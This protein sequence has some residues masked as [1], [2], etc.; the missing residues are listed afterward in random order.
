MQ[1]VIYADTLFL[2][3]FF[4]NTVVLLI[5]D[6]LIAA[7][8]PIWRLFVSAAVGAAYSLLMFFEGF[9]FL[10]GVAL[11]VLILFGIFSIAFGNCGVLASFK[12]FGTFLLV[13]ALLGGVLLALIFL[14]DFGTALGSVVSGSEIYINMSPFVLIFGILGVYALLGLYRRMQCARLYEESLIRRV[15]IDYKGKT[16]EVNL[17]ADTGLRACDPLSCEGVVIAEYL[18]IRLILS[19][20]E[21]KIIEENAAL[22]RAYAAKMR[23]IPYKTLCGENRIF[24]IVAN[25]AGEDFEKKRVTVGLVKDKKFGANYRGLINPELIFEAKREKECVL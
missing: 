18:A 13:N 19:E 2:F 25:I 11:K 5:T 20:E 12:K 6:K 22:E 14:T 4:M 8:A 15:K 3:N 16:A 21:R 7:F 10:Y 24:G 9:G 17:F 23:V 1:P